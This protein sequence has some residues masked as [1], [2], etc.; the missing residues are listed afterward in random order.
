MP[1]VFLE[2]TDPRDLN[3]YGS[4]IDHKKPA[5]HRDYIL[6]FE[7]FVT[8]DTD[9][10]IYFGVKSDSWRS[11][12]GTPCLF[13]GARKLGEDYKKA[14]SRELK[15]ESKNCLTFQGNPMIFFGGAARTFYWSPNV[16]GNIHNFHGAAGEEMKDILAISATY[17]ATHNN[18]VRELGNEL[19]DLVDAN[20]GR[21]QFL[22]SDT[23]AA[24]RHWLSVIFPQICRQN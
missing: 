18:N 13:G 6:L 1:K 5:E 4:S 17:L 3:I 20:A 24:I 16:A 11:Y 12:P 15:E 22:R 7:K 21:E 2:S 10:L 14:L 9:G 23:L 8:D 19:C